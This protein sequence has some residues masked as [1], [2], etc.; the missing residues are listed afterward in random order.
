MTSED[1]G[2]TG[3][4]SRP[5]LDSALGDGWVEIGDG[6]RFWGRFGAAGLLLRDPSGRVL[7]QHRVSWSHFGNTWGLPGGARHPEESAFQA[8]LRESEEEA[9]VPAGLIVPVLSSVVTIGPWSYSTVV[10][11][12]LEHFTPRITDAE[13]EELRWVAPED[14]DTLPLHPGFAEAWPGLRLLAAPLP[15]LVIDAAN[16]VGSRPDGWWRDRAGAAQRLLLALAR[17]ARTGVPGALLGIDAETV[18]PCIAV[19]LEGAAR[20]ADATAAVEA[21]PS[22]RLVVDSAEGSGDD[23]IVDLVA[24]LDSAVVVTADRGLVARIEALGATAM[25]PRSV[26]DLLDAARE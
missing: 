8:A 25:G 7:L 11:D 14:V 13:S 22:G 15:V 10:A 23:A 20:A 1:T 21:A 18:W 26:L 5:P 3:L 6:R 19:V 2:G 12:T 17:L 16:V 4:P 24:R 9:G